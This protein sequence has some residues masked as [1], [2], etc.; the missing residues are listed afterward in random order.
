MRTPRLPAVDWTD[1]PPADLNGL[2]RFARKAKSAFCACAVTFQL[3]SSAMPVTQ[4]NGG[5]LE[6]MVRFT[7]LHAGLAVRIC[8]SCQGLSSRNID[9]NKHQTIRGLV[10]ANGEQQ[11]T[12]KNFLY[13]NFLDTICIIH[14]TRQMIQ[15][16]VSHCCKHNLHVTPVETD[17]L[18][19]CIP[20]M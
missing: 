12:F 9:C 17:D 3:A 6:G 4:K 1:A 2:V 20:W 19:W 16:Y 11:Y 10:L 8:R 13:F 7:Y 18:I 15:F 5:D 14:F